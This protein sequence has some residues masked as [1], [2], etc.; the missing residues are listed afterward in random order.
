MRILNMPGII[1]NSSPIIHLAK[2]G[3][4]N[5]LHEFYGTVTVPNAVYEECVTEGGDGVVNHQTTSMK[6]K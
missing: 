2:I 3:R 6:G 1:S 4:L 5:L